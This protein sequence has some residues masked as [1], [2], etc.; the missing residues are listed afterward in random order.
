MK[1]KLSQLHVYYIS[2]IAPS[3]DFEEDTNELLSDAYLREDHFAADASEI[4]VSELNKGQS[5]SRQ[6]LSC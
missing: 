4:E 3:Q 6:F 5:N 1:L 2:T